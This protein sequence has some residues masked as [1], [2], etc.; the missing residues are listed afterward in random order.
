MQ[1]F[2]ESHS[3]L[4]GVKPTTTYTKAHN[5]C[6]GYQFNTR[7]NVMDGTV[8]NID[9]FNKIILFFFVIAAL[10]HF[11]MLPLSITEYWHFTKCI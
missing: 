5:T 11:K 8:I 9:F 1:P 2:I 10:E 4:I 6:L 7:G 3:Q